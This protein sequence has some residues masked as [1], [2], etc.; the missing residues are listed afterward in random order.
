MIK[1]LQ[2]NYEHGD[3]L[4]SVQVHLDPVEQFVI[5]SESR[6]VTLS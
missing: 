2:R 1:A 6:N 3:I 4:T 5:I